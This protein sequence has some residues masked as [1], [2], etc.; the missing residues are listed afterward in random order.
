MEKEKEEEKIIINFEGEREVPVSRA[1]IE[2]GG[3]VLVVLPEKSDELL[4]APQEK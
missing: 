3:I 2:S 4:S 1:A